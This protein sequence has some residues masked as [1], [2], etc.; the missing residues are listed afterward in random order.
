MKKSFKN[1]Q[2]HY[3]RWVNLIESKKNCKLL[4][5]FAR[6]VKDQFYI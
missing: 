5:F 2:I 3:N 4:L 6:V 1:K